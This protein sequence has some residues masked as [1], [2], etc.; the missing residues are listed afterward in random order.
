MVRHT[1]GLTLT[2]AILV[3]CN[4]CPELPPVDDPWEGEVPEDPSVDAEGED[5][6]PVEG[7]EEPQDIPDDPVADFLLQ[8]ENDI[9][10][11][12][13]QERVAKGLSELFLCTY[14]R[15][16]ARAHSQDM[17]D[18]DYFAHTNLDGQ[19]GGD[20]LSLVKIPWRRYGENLAYTYGYEDPAAASI[21]GWMN[22]PGHRENILNGKF[23]H[24]GVGVFCDTKGAFYITQDFY[25]F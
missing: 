23:T 22:S 18:N 6:L 20:R 8:I 15:A 5:T 9:F 1:L 24:V 21:E 3:L 4:G 2:C 10:A 14:A 7:E 16:A 19:T 25:S 11:M 12:T 17:A 13:N